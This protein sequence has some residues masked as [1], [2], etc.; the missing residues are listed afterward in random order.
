MEPQEKQLHQHLKGALEQVVSFTEPAWSAL[1][2]KLNPHQ[3]QKGD[4]IFH[5]EDTNI[6]MHFL[7]NGLVRLCY[8]RNDGKEFNKSFLKPGDTVASIGMLI[9]KRPPRFSAQCLKDSATLSVPYET[10]RHLFDTF[11]CWDRLGRIL[12]AK[13]A[14]KKELREEQLLMDDA[15][16]R[17]Q[18]FMDQFGSLAE[19]IP[20]YQVASY[21]G[22]TDVALSRIRKRLGLV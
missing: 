3:Y 18:L 14:L 12:F 2:E 5:A 15:T 17:Y 22:I 1:E 16:Q 4:Y 8:L 7:L 6:E 9:N 10:I 13:L 11:P 21:L 20:L 19:E